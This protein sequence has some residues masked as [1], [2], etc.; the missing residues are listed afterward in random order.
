MRSLV[1]VSHEQAYNQNFVGFKVARITPSYVLAPL[2]VS[3]QTVPDRINH[4]SE[5][6]RTS[7]EVFVSSKTYMHYMQ[8]DSTNHSSAF[9]DG[10][11]AANLEK[12]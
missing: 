2:F 7:A 9:V 4:W 8:L 11:N 12:L 3:D 1:V 6:F 10:S 5:N